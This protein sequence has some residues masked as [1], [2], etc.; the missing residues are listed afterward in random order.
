MIFSYYIK[1]GPP[2]CQMA[3]MSQ[4]KEKER[5]SLGKEF[6][7]RVEMEDEFLRKYYFIAKATSI[8]KAIC[9][10]TQGLSE[11]LHEAW[12]RLIDLTRECPHHGVSNH[13]LT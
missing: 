3:C 11:T 10:F 6:T 4:F 2:N 7:S 13:E 1:W 9:K 12:E 8:R 5:C